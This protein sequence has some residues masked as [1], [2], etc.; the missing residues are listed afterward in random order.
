MYPV[1]RSTHR[2]QRLHSSLK[3]LL[4]GLLLSSLLA[5]GWVDSTGVQRGDEP[6]VELSF[7]NV[8]NLIENEAMLLDPVQ[9]VDPFGEIVFWR[10]SENP[11]NQGNL[12]RC[13][14]VNGFNQQFV[15]NSLAQACTTS[16]G[17]AME[18]E[19]NTQN[20]EGSARTVFRLVPPLLRAPVG[21]VYQLFGTDADGLETVNDFTFCLIAV[22]EAPDAQDDM[23]IALEGEMFTTSANGPNL[24]S[25]DS[26]D[27]DISNLALRVL[28][29]PVVEPRFAASFEI[30]PDGS[31]TYLPVAGFSGNDMFTY[32]ITDG[33]A[34]SE[35]VARLSIQAANAE[36]V[37]LDDL[38]ALD[39]IEGLAVDEV[40]A[41]FFVDPEG[42]S[43]VF[44]AEGLPPGLVLDDEGNLSGTVSAGFTGNFTFTISVTDGSAILVSEAS[45]TVAPNLPPVARNLPGLEGQEGRVFIFDASDF[46][47]DP[48]EQPLLYALSTP[49][50]LALNIG[51]GSGVVSGVPSTAGRFRITVSASDGVNPST[52]RVA[53]LD[54]DAI[55][56]R[57]PVFS[58][59]I[60]NQ[61]AIVDE[62]FEL[63]IVATDDDDDDL[64][65][66]LAGT[67]SR[68]I[69]IDEES[70]EIEGEFTSAG[71]FRA[72][73]RVSDG[74][75]TTAATFL[76]FVE[77][78]PVVTPAVNQI[79]QAVDIPN[80]QVAGGF[81]FTVFEQ[82]DDPD[83]DTLTFSTDD[84]PVGV[85]LSDDGVI[86]GTASAANA[87]NHFVVVTANDGRGGEVSDGFRLTIVN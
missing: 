35:A 46:F 51:A 74:T 60:T 78:L 43:L 40:L 42:G 32:R 85:T 36:P 53:I 79:P 65:F 44:S 8:I 58:G 59:A 6:V 30:F 67:A 7:N 11:V 76:I 33:F 75:D 18:F 66:S 29:E 34:T 5:C 72:N 54:V 16:A 27:I 45:G 4:T 80:R 13:A 62:P 83:G 17:C 86:S 81:A 19:Q 12:Q 15:Q 38:P 14:G 47:E 49:A 84:L 24:L 22:N 87:G 82:F 10:W 28:P 31:F 1:V 73:I 64:T 70:G 37:Q 39:L 57:V 77:E 2:Y 56:N 26:D 61:S 69:D 71:T 23:F 41:E 20:I 52:Q 68:F 21:V 25:N 9:S 3:F 50:G 48:E 55:P 63:V